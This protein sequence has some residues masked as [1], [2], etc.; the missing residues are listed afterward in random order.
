MRRFRALVGTTIATAALAALVAAPAD[1]QV[2]NST[3]AIAIPAA[4]NTSGVANPYPSAINVS[5]TT[6]TISNVKV[7]LTGLTHRFAAD[8]DLL[9]V[10]PSGQNVVLLAD[11]GGNNQITNINLTFDQA[12]PGLVPTPIVS[13]TFRPTNLGSFA[14]PA[15]APAP[16]FGASL[17]LFNGTVANGAWNLFAFDDLPGGAGSLASWSLDITTNGPTL[18]SFAPTT[19]AP[20][21]TVVLTGT[22]LT[23]ATAVSFAGTAAASFTVVSPTQITAVVPA[24]APSGP[25]TV[26]TPTG[27]TSTATPF[28]TTP[29]PTVTSVAPNAGKVGTAVTI[30]GTNFTG[31]TSLTF[32]GVPAVGF[33]VTAP[34]TITATV[35][36][37]AGTG[38]VAV[39]TPG[40]NASSTTPF[41][42]SHDR[43]ISASLSGRNSAKGTVSVADG[44]TRCAGSV[45]VTLQRQRRGGGW[46][47]VGTAVTQATGKYS[48]GGTR[49]KGKYR[50]VAQ[51]TTLQSGDQCLKAT[52]GA[53]RRR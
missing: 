11:V 24:G 40:G 41:V 21:S 23:G 44:F 12:A 37:G 13:G 1:A 31:A 25:I 38:P 52:S 8:V 18:T 15:P 53:F 33:Q 43:T 2:F 42:V 9:L 45:Q 28:Q 47:Q 49:T 14:G 50:V 3:G 16:P 46:G 32:G 5:G 34:T 17:A 10:G 48:V 30:N 51:A 20:G 22:N 27:T 39:V 4:P 29:P 36:T 6:G 26:T 7:S 19:G 35:P